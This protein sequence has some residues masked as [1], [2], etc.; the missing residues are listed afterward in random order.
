[1]LVTLKLYEILSNKRALKDRHGLDYKDG[2]S[3]YTS[4]VVVFQASYY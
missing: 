2:E 4:F 3:T 1:M